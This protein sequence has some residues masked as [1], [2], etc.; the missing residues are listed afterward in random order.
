MLLD[1]GLSGKRPDALMNFCA[2]GM[3]PEE[4]RAWLK[5]QNFRRPLSADLRQALKKWY[6][7][8]ADSIRYAEGFEVCELGKQPSEKDLRNLF[9]FFPA[10]Q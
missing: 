9:P 4:R 3:G 8:A 2:G 7:A 1:E 6:G 5:D 10:A